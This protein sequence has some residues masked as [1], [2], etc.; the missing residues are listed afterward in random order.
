MSILNKL[1]NL[2]AASSEN[3]RVAMTEEQVI[4]CREALKR[5]NRGYNVNPNK[6]DIAL[7][8]RVAINYNDEWVNF[9]NF[10]SADVAAAIGTIVSAAYF[11]ENARAGSFDES[12]VENSEPFLKWLADPRNAEVI[13]RANGEKPPVHGSTTKSSVAD[14]NIF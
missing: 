10:A 1:K 13:A 11:G 9:G 5:D 2:K 3:A 8:Y 12:K 4:K 6:F 14:E 7:P